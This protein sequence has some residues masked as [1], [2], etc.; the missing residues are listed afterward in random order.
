MLTHR[1]TRFIFI[2]LTIPIFF[3]LT[4]EAGAKS[5]FD[6]E[7]ELQTIYDDN[8]IN[9]SD[10][11]LDQFDDPEAPDNKFAIKSK[12][13]FIVNP[14]ITLIY[15]T[16]LWNHSFHLGFKTDYYYYSENDVKRHWRFETYFR[17]YFKKG[18]YFKGS[19]SYLPDYYYRNSYI[20]G[21]GYR[22]AEFDKITLEGKFVYQLFKTTLVS[23]TYSY[24]NK[25]FT[26]AFDERDI[27]EH[28][29]G[30]ALVYRPIKLWKGWL[31]YAY[32]HA[33]GA[34][35]DNDEYSRDTSFDQNQFTVGNRLYLRGLANKGF[36]IAGKLTYKFVQYQTTKITSEDRYRL[37]REDTR[38]YLYAMVKHYIARGVS[39]EAIYKNYS[40][41]VEIPADDLK[42]LLESSS[43]SIYFI[44]NYSL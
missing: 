33:V 17:R 38:L 16:R 10:A 7:A 3:Y 43:N 24:S 21:E 13:D 27:F 39:L 1:I 35:A 26:V 31:G 11:D 41:N 42:E 5:K 9:Y 4:A 29:I 30:G 15:K 28:E 34:G 25:D 2:C 8:V 20:S 6:L 19:V 18:T 32:T 40:K 23:L 37:G 12:D 14:E 22:E 44:I 36:Q